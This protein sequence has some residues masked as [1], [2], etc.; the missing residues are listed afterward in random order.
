MEELSVK[1]RKRNRFLSKCCEML[2]SCGTGTIEK[3]KSAWKRDLEI[4]LNEDNWSN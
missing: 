1:D 3:S 2:R 4:D